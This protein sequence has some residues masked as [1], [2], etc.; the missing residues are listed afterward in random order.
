MTFVVSI[1]LGVYG[2]IGFI[3]IWLMVYNRNYCTN[4][5]YIVMSILDMFRTTVFVGN[6]IAAN[7]QL[8]QPF[9]VLAFFL[10]LKIP[11]YIIT[12]FYAFHTY[13]ELKG[14]YIES[15]SNSISLS[16]FS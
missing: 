12:I 16:T 15:D 6:Y 10:L 4:V 11:F 13:R 2:L 7:G 3:A 8:Y 14:L 9:G 1:S 5:C